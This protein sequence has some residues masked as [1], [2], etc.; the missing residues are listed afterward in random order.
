[1]IDITEFSECYFRA[2]T[3]TEDAVILRAGEDDDQRVV[4]LDSP[5]LLAHMRRLV[6]SRSQAQA[7]AGVLNEVFKAI[8]DDWT[9]IQRLQSPAPLRRR[10]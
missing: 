9:I 8:S 5:D 3:F 7:M 10:G 1:M 6:A 4:V 2:V